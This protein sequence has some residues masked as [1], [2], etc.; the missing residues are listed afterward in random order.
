MQPKEKPEGYYLDIH[1]SL[2][3]PLLIGGIDRNLCLGLWTMGMAIGVTLR[4]YWFFGVV[5]AL[6]LLVRK[7]TQRDPDYFK[8]VLNHIHD[9]AYFDV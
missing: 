4:M 6:H 1:K 8:T 5:I 9:K 2:V 7:M 3:E